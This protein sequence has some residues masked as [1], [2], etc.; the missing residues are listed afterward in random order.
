MIQNQA[1]NLS[2]PLSTADDGGTVR[3]Y[4]TSLTQHRQLKFLGEPNPDKNEGFVMHQVFFLRDCTKALVPC[5]TIY[6]SATTQCY[7]DL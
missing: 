7:T 5:D 6:S 1:Q 2:L 3:V 4:L